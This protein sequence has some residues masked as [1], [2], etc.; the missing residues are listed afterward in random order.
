MDIFIWNHALDICLNGN[1]VT[2][3]NTDLTAGDMDLTQAKKLCYNLH[4]AFLG[5][6]KKGPF[7]ISGDLAWEW[8]RLPANPN[9]KHNAEV[10]KPWMSGADVTRRP[11][12]KWIIDFGH[13]MLESEVAL[14][15]APYD[16]IHKHVKP[17]RIQ[18]NRS[19]LRRNWWRHDRSGK[20]LFQ[21]IDALNRY[22]DTAKIAKHRLFVWL[23]ARILPDQQLI[24]MAR[25][26]DTFFG[27]LHSRF[28]EA[29][30]LRFGTNLGGNSCYTPTTAFATFPFPDGLSPDIP[31]S[32]YKEDKQAIAIA[33]A[34]LR[35]GELRNRW[36]NPP[37]WVEWVDGPVPGYP[38]RPVARNEATAEKLKKRT[39]TKLYNT[40]P[41]WLDDAHAAL[42]TTVAEAYGW[43]ASIPNDDA[44]RELLALNLAKSS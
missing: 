11:S 29:W 37:E 12:G 44:L 14:F 3:I 38:S 1:K 16:Y 8:L 32:N 20:K 19:D 7:D 9:G 43:D 25:D 30:S 2:R 40:R 6:Y 15:E 31:A 22:I 39:L 23:D 10:L 34:S 35:L 27:I 42:D 13:S 33:N 41:Q 4:T 21:K 36:L 17:K 28:H 18:N 24:V 5:G 26:D